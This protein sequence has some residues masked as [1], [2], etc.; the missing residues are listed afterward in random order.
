MTWLARLDTKNPPTW[1]IINSVTRQT[2]CFGLSKQD[3][4]MLCKQRN[5][6]QNK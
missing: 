4:E 1:E 5:K 2:I 3:A 6:K